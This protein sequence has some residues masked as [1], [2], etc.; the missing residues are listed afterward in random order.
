MIKDNLISLLER[1]IETLQTNRDIFF[2][3]C[4]VL[5]VLRIENE[6]FDTEAILVKLKN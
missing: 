3:S 6:I 2:R 1:R 4:D 5:E